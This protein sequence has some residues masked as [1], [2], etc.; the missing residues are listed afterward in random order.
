MRNELQHRE[1]SGR[2]GQGLDERKYE[3]TYVRVTTL[4]RES[5][6]NTR[7]YKTYVRTY[8]HTGMRAVAQ[9]LFG[10]SSVPSFKAC[11]QSGEVR[12]REPQPRHYTTSIGSS[13]HAS[14]TGWTAALRR[15]R[16][17]AFRVACPRR[18]LRPIGRVAKRTSRASPPRCR[19][20]LSWQHCSRIMAGMDTFLWS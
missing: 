10:H 16:M 20:C 13:Y 5:S 4:G 7:M 14:P 6:Y 8:V 1:A 12:R 18:H 19:R 2:E 17:A 9:N 3:R 11:A 15:G